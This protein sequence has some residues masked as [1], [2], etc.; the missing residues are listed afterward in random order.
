MEAGAG[1]N[2]M[3]W[4]M[5]AYTFLHTYTITLLLEITTFNSLY[6]VYTWICFI[7]MRNMSNHKI[8]TFKVGVS[9]MKII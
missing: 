7:Y 4:P 8:H 5:C 1:Q 9:G 6:L 3:I 2:N